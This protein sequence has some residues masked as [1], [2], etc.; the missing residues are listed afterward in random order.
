MKILLPL[1]AAIALF[2]L[3]SAHALT[4]YTSKAAL[5]AAATTALVEDFESTG[6]VSGDVLSSFNHNG[7]TFTGLAGVP[8]PNVV[9]NPPG[10]MSYG[11]GVV[12]PL[13]TSVLTANGAVD[14]FVD[15]STPY[16]AVGLDIYLNGLGPLDVRVYD[17]A[18]LL[19]TYTFPG[20]QD[21]KAYLGF[22]NDTP[23]TGFE[24]VSSGGASINTA[25]DNISAAESIP[26][27][28]TLG[29]LALACLS[30]GLRRRRA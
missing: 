13:M 4:F 11:A 16:R 28:G 18:S 3:Q 20:T 30:L 23:V 25:M 19:G 15:F 7:L 10:E 14:I 21:D 5:D 29:V 17:G 2:S 8:F 1:A 12:V 27:P 26:E 22:T 24:F 9:V 6:Q